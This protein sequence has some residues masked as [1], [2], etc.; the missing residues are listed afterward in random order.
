M[1]KKNILLLSGIIVFVVLCG[2]LLL[3]KGETKEQSGT[4][5]GLIITGKKDEGGWNEAH[6]DAMKQACKEQGAELIV[7]ESIH[8]GTGECFPVIDELAKEG[9][10][11][12]FM[13]GYAYGKEVST[14]AYKYPKIA[15]FQIDENYIGKNVSSY[16]GRMYQARYLSGIVAGRMTKTNHIGYVAA[17]KTPEVLRGINAF[18]LGAKKVNKNVKVYVK[19]TG[20]WDNDKLEK[21]YAEGLIKDYNVDLLTYHENKTNVIDV[22][23]E[24]NIYSIGYHFNDSE[25]YSSK[26]L[27]SAVW[28]FKKFYKDR[29]RDFETTG[30]IKAESYWYG[31]KEGIVDLGKYSEL[32]D[33]ETK[34]DLDKARE[35]MCNGWDVFS[36]PIYDKEKILR[37]DKNEQLSD[38]YLQTQINWLVDGVVEK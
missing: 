24:N 17:M 32:I 18:T 30:S 10:N 8:E 13:A 2:I 35:D 1:N 11:M 4:K 36:G 9:A 26:Y 34:K 3:F 28:N 38:K 29:I 27:T 33:S 31:V 14:C 37:V 22:A 5:V 12:I 23:E 15:F 21:E 25:R 6:Y 16:F 19:W 7:K 20:S